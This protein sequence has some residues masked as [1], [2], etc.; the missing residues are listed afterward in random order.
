MAC[1]IDNSAQIELFVIRQE[2]RPLRVTQKAG[3]F[4]VKVTQQRE[5]ILFN[6]IFSNRLLKVLAPIQY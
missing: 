2:L 4:F 5:V 3:R 6:L 1:K